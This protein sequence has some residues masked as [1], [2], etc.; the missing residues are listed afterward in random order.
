MFA[1]RVQL[2][3][4][5]SAPLRTAPLQFLLFVYKAETF[6][7]PELELEVVLMVGAME[8]VVMESGLEELGDGRVMMAVVICCPLQFICA[9]SLG[10]RLRLERQLEETGTFKNAVLIAEF[11]MKP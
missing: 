11:N 3:A 6:T 10:F 1:R 7:I 8:Q 5:G 9:R 4:H 2:E